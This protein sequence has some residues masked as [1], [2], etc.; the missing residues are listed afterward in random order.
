MTTPTSEQI[1]E[2]VEHLT[3]YMPSFDASQRHVKTLLSAL[4]SKD[5]EIEFYKRRNVEV[6]MLAHKWMIAHDLLAA[7]KPYDFP[8][9]TDVPAA[10]ARAT[11]AEA[12]RDALIAERDTLRRALTG[13]PS[14]T[15]VGDNATRYGDPS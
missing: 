14:M 10:L 15:R 11:Q 4:T 13:A 7:G 3:Y 5:E 12:E 2:A 9:P 6:S 1:A 8:S